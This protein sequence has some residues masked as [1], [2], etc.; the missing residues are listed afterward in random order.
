MFA[1]ASIEELSRFYRG[2][3]GK[4][5]N[6][7]WSVLVSN[8]ADK[9]A[10]FA[11]RYFPTFNDIVHD[12]WHLAVFATHTDGKWMP[13]ERLHSLVSDIPNKLREKGVGS[14]D[15]GILFFNP[16]TNIEEID[17]EGKNSIVYLPLDYNSIGNMNLYR[18]GIESTYKCILKTFEH[19]N[20]H[21]HRPIPRNRYNDFILNLR[22]AIYR[23]KYT[24]YLLSFSKEFAK[25]RL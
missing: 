2:Q 17:V 9:S 24:H 21:Y 13:C 19:M 20:L 11:R 12:G 1:A 8:S 10:E 6:G 7:I 18:S 15:F 22:A 23:E 4:I 16:S 5:E 14:Y 25:A 3:G